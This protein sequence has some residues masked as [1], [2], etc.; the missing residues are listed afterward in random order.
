LS[1]LL[2]LAVFTY[3]T[4]LLLLPILMI[5]VA[6]MFDWQEKQKLLITESI[7]LAVF[8]LGLAVLLPVAAQKSGI[9][10]FTDET[11]WSQWAA[12]RSSLTSPWN[13]L[14]GNRY[15]Y[16]LAI[17]VKNFINSFSPKFLVTRGGSHPWHSLPTM[18]HIF[19]VAY[20]FAFA[21]IAKAATMLWQAR[22]KLADFKKQ[23]ALLFLLLAS[24]AP[25]IITV[26]APHATRSLLFLVLLQ[27][28]A[29]LG[30]AALLESVKDNYYNLIWQ[31]TVAALAF[32]ALLHAH[33]LFMVYPNQ[34]E[35]FQ[36]G[37]DQVVQRIEREHPQANVAVVDPAGY[38]YILLAWYL[39]ISPETYFKTVIRQDPNQIGF[40]Y[41]EQVTH[42]HFIADPKDRAPNESV[43][44]QWSEADGAWQTEEDL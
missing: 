14:A 25:A 42:Y 27:V 3:N 16:Y 5:F 24:L 20:V 37:F 2:L 19:D 31:L 41:G 28:F 11:V 33:R 38:H 18:G 1:L 12:W 43:L 15:V 39:K 6:L 4:P 10:I 22:K 17:M 7:L 35:A 40:R 9:T 8:L 32:S 21:G 29:A 23:G 44:I 36:P 26:D 30:I 34:Q 13:R